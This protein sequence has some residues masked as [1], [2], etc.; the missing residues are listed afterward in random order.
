[1]DFE[2]ALAPY[3]GRRVEVFSTNSFV[4]GNLLSAGNGTISVNAVS[5]GYSSPAGPLT[6]NI[7]NVE[8]IRVLAG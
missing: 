8:F 7:A 5:S 2:E 4:Q 3:V 6:I 1:M